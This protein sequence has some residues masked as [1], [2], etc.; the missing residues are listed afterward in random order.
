MRGQVLPFA[1]FAPLS[2]LGALVM[3]DA[4]ASEGSRMRGHTHE[5]SGLA[6]CL[7][8]LRALLRNHQHRRIDSARHDRGGA[9]TQ[10]FQ[11]IG[12]HFAVDRGRRI[13]FAH[14][15]QMK[16]PGADFAFSVARSLS[17]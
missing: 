13:R 7:N 6:F 14:T 8:V 11:P 2:S 5:G 9:D 1:H 3:P 17:L 15:D 16:N 4:I 12:F 10:A